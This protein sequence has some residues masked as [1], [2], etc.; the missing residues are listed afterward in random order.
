LRLYPDRYQILFWVGTS[1][2]RETFDYVEHGLHFDVVDGGLL[3]SRPLPRS[4][5]IIFLTP[6]WVRVERRVI[7]ELEAGIAHCK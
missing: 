6:S 3:T 2:G 1:D 4:S 5:G 7:G